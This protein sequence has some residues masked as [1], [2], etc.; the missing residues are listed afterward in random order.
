M[1]EKKA[2][3]YESPIT[4][5]VLMLDLNKLNN[6]IRCESFH[7]NFMSNLNQ[8]DYLNVIFFDIEFDFKKKLNR[9]RLNF[10]F[11]GRSY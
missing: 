4:S 1:P 2:D 3:T 10:H 9:K 7:T 5:N 6:A 8:S 11:L